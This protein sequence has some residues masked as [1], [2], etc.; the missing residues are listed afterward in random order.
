MAWTLWAEEEWVGENRAS[1]HEQGWSG[2][3]SGVWSVVSGDFV[4]DAGRARIASSTF[5]VNLAYNRVSP[6]HD[7]TRLEV[8]VLD[9]EIM[10]LGRVDRSTKNSYYLVHLHGQQVILYRVLGGVATWLGQADA[11]DAGDDVLTLETYLSFVRVRW[12]GV[13]ILEYEDTTPDVLLQGA[14]GIKCYE[15]SVYFGGLR[16]YYDNALEM[17]SPPLTTVPVSTPAPP[18]TAAPTTAPPTTA[19]EPTFPPSTAAPTT[20]VSTTLAPTTPAPTTPAP[21]T[22]GPTTPSPLTPGPVTSGTTV[23][24]TVSYVESE[25]LLVVRAWMEDWQGRPRTDDLSAMAMT[26]WSEHGRHLVVAGAEDPAG[27]HIARFAVPQ[28]RL[29][30]QHLYLLELTLVAD[31]DEGHRIIGMPVN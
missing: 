27:G 20:A 11:V 26:I 25:D 6:Y 19:P 24:A 2:G 28:A 5:T 10:L 15:P 29:W 3:G 1:I 12:N 16:M 30:A 4:Y 8:D 23:S 22:I 7:A 31:G 14:M 21:T 17:G 18:T 13:Q 9:K